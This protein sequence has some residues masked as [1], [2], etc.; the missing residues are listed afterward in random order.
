MID[1]IGIL[2]QTWIGLHGPAPQPPA[3]PITVMA[4]MKAAK[5]Q[6]STMPLVGTPAAGAAAGSAATK[7][8]A[9]GPAKTPASKTPAPKTPAADPKKAADTKTPAP[10]ADA[11]LP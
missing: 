2:A 1:I 7:A 11:K 8:P 6:I 4:R 3:Q 9:P 5:Q 10:A